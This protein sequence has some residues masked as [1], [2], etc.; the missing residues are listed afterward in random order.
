MYLGNTYCNKLLLVI[1]AQNCPAC[2]IFSNEQLPGI[3]SGIK[4]YNLKVETTVL[5]INQVG[6]IVDSVYPEECNLYTNRTPNLLLIDRELWR[7]KSSL[8]VFSV[9]EER[10][11][12]NEVLLWLGRNIFVA[13]RILHKNQ[14]VT[15]RKISNF[16]SY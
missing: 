10:L 16:R 9:F 11:L 8:K 6:G 3:I 15:I 4:K 12:R 2:A 1:S 7:E 14:L 13:D 5:N